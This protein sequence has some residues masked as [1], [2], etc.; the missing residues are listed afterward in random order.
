MHRLNQLFA[1]LR[2]E[3][4]RVK[5]YESPIGLGELADFCRDY[6][7]CEN[8]VLDAVNAQVI[9]YDGQEMPFS[10]GEVD[11]LIRALD[12]GGRYD[13]LTA[14]TLF[15]LDRPRAYRALAGML[16][17]PEHRAAF[18]RDFGRFSHFEHVRAE[19]ATLGIT[20]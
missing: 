4:W 18:V 7:A 19:L 5:R 13:R 15:V 9:Q 16:G 8:L 12:T 20:L 11:A 6:A 10:D 2:E 1:E 17:P 3:L 14:E